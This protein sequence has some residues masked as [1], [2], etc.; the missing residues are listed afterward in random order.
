MITPIVR[1]GSLAVISYLE[2]GDRT[3]SYI[4]VDRFQPMAVIQAV[5]EMRNS[6]SASVNNP[7]PHKTNEEWSNMVEGMKIALAWV[8]VTVLAMA[9]DRFK[10]EE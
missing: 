9:E 1:S 5:D 8:Q 2:I 4:T 6:L 3:M 7:P 10:E